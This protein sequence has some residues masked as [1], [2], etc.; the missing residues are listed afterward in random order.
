MNKQTYSLKLL[1]SGSDGNAALFSTTS[2]TV[3]ID[4]GRTAKA[5]TAALSMLA[6]DPDSISAIFL[7]HEHRDHTAALDVFLKHHKIPVHT[8]KASAERLRQTAG[9]ALL[10]CLV[11]H[12]PLFTEQIGALTVTSFETS[13]DS[14]CS[15][16]YRLS[17]ATGDAVHHIGYATDLGAVTP[18]VER[19]LFGCE[20]VV[21]EANHD[22]ELLMTGPYPYDLKR[23]IASRHGHLSNRDCAA[24][25]ARL[26]AN[27]TRRVLLAH[28][29]ETNNEPSLALGEVGAALAGTGAHVTA[30]DPYIITEL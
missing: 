6:V 18:T 9:D 24:L 16:G 23:R 12:P 14:A 3:L 1:Y 27:G 10:A 5:L 25:C 8:T 22:E 13:H 20:A 15:V 11:E 2:A 7:T 4:A 29:S 17:L 28:L 21:I 26:A 19:A 30:A